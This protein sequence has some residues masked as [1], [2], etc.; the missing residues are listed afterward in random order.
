MATEPVMAMA[1]ADASPHSG[2]PQAG[3]RR[4][5]NERDEDEMSD[6][7]SDID[8]LR[9]E[10]QSLRRDTSGERRLRGRIASALAGVSLVALPVVAYT[11]FNKP[12][13]DFQPSTPISSA[14][15]NSLFD[16]IYAGLNTLEQRHQTCAAGT[17]RIGDQCVDDTGQVGTWAQATGLCNAA[18]KTVCSVET[19]QVCDLVNP[20]GTDCTSLTDAPAGTT[21]WTSTSVAGAGQVAS[22]FQVAFAG[23]G[24]LVVDDVTGGGIARNYLCC[25]TVL[26]PPA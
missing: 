21:T 15:V 20:A 3:I 5:G 19:L 4:V 6:E 22:A 8:A 23:D 7:Q 2:T 24:T 18:G 26:P 13:A 16:D 25:S 17:T 14:D 12:V 10:V 9:R 1:M 11:A